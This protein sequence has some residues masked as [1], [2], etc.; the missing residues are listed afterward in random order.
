MEKRSLSGVAS[1]L[2]CPAG[3][4]EPTDLGH[5]TAGEELC[6]LSGLSEWFKV[7]NDRCVPIACRVHH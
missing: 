4:P 7:T 3:A 6:F 2:A 5:E 1:E